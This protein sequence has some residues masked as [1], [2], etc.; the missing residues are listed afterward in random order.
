M[1]SLH[2]YSLQKGKRAD[3]RTRGPTHVSHSHHNTTYQ[4][5]EEGPALIPIASLTHSYNLQLYF[6]PINFGGYWLTTA[7][8]FL[9]DGHSLFVWSLNKAGSTPC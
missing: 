8:I 1:K 5:T 2:C 9:L 3:E 4:S 7:T 6:Q